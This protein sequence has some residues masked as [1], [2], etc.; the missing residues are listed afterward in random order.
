MRKLKIGL[1]FDDSL[2]KPDGVQQFVLTLGGWLASR[3][4]DVHYLVGQTKRSDLPNI[5][6]LSRN[7][8]VRFNKNRM[9]MPLPARS[10]VLKEL[11]DH[12][13]FDV[14][15]VQ[16]PYSPMLAGK[17][18]DA[19]GKFTAVI[20]T[21]HV[22]PHSGLVTAGSRA[23][24]VWVR[25]SIKRFDAMTA[26]SVPAQAFAKRAFRINS[27]VVAL[28]LRLQPFF[29]AE[30]YSRYKDTQNVVFLGRLVERKG[31]QYLIKAVAQLHEHGLWP[32]DARLIICGKGP[33]EPKLKQLV[34][35]KHLDGFTEFAGFITEESKPR[36]L[37]SA[38]IAVYPS[39]GGE[40]FGIVLL[41]AMA[42]CRGLVLA[43]DN[44]GY[45]S[46]MSPRP[47]S[48]FDPHDTDLFAKKIF[49]GLT[50]KS[51]RAKAQKWQ[52][53]YVVQFDA[54]TIGRHFVDIYEQ[55]L[56]KRSQ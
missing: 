38:D 12:E 23:L 6:S 36:Y 56:H 15:H 52:R 21:F 34:K 45:A 51:E 11:L 1:V 50:D 20:G 18:I 40:S 3:G 9:A 7:I 55:A 43:G 24:R 42:A 39:T 22:A 54:S 30:T 14:L 17:I 13:K 37:A 46:V 41:E 2:D 26:T 8:N 10:K 29:K 5:H 33:L 27:D 25:K 48:L 49:Q 4:H 31:C 16:V 28:P 35:E 44:P 32:E 19:A 53:D 47:N